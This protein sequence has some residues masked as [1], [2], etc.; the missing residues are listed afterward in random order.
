M[1]LKERHVTYHILFWIVYFTL[2]T[3]RWGAYFNS[4]SY[5]FN[6]NLLGFSI[7]ISLA[8]F[9]AYFLLPKFIPN[10][11]YG[12][13]VLSLL[14]SLAVMLSLKLV[15]TYLFINQN[16]WPEASSQQQ[17]LGFSHVMELVLGEL[18]VMGITTS[19]KLT[20]DWIQQQQKNRALERQ[21]M[22]T[23]L[24]LLKS[25]I[26]P[27]FFFNTL[28]NLYS[29][30]LVNSPMASETVL[31]LSELMSYMLYQKKQKVALSEEIRYI[32]H[33]LDLEKLRFGNRL[34]LD[35]EI[36]GDL[37]AYEVTPLIFL[38]FIENTFKHGTKNRINNINI[39]MKLDLTKKSIT[40][41]CE[42]PIPSKTNEHA[43]LEANTNS[44]F[45]KGGLGIQNAK[46]RLDLL[47]SDKY[48]LDISESSDI[49]KVTLK[50]PST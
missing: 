21:Q 40:F 43:F 18:Y 37:S 35:F 28:N 36:N 49:Y 4:Y 2:N 19:I 50:L 23:E 15:L 45:I 24:N 11:K 47:Y 34:K 32:Q 12:L 20:I 22:E 31:K 6:S 46:R 17:I 16:V 48:E 38:P 44:S 7:H 10:K 42:N 8:Y 13:Y 9:H 14:S 30:T 1:K 25:Q 29:L 3:L 39:N 26:Q 41:T 5:S 33:Y 27:H